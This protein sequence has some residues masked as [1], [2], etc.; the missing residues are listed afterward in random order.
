M[1]DYQRAGGEL[2]LGTPKT[3]LCAGE[4]LNPEFEIAWHEETGIPLS[5]LIGTTEF[6]H[7][8]VGFRPGVDEIKRET[9]RGNRSDVLEKLQRIHDCRGCSAGQIFSRHDSL[10]VGATAILARQSE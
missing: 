5:Q 9:L 3:L 7:A 2:S 1:L 4:P 10:I 8:F 6:L